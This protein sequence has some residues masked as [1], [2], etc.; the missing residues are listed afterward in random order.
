MRE[1]PER[2]RA[3]NTL[4]SGERDRGLKLVSQWTPKFETVVAVLNGGGVNSTNYPTTDPTSSKDVVARA[5]YSQGTIDGAVSYYTGKEIT[6]LTG[7]DVST[8]KTRIGFDAQLVYALP[9]V[10]GGSFKGEFYGGQNLN[11]DSLRVLVPAPASG[12][13]TLLKSGANSDHLATDFTGFYMMWVQ[14][15]GEKLQFAGRYD[16]FDPNT[17]LEHDQYERVGLGLNWFWD[18]FTRVTAAYDIQTTDRLVS[19]KYVD[20]KDNLWTV[21][22]QHKF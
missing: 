22:F 5:R 6:P 8:D 3:E 17:D 12:G 7:P 20:P 9:T 16:A 11:A 4:F 18:G 19:G 15:L 13:P 2:S 10:G 14:N 1:L 21:Q